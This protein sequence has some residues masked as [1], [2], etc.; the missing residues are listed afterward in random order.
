MAEPRPR[1][2]HVHDGRSSTTHYVVHECPNCFKRRLC[3]FPALSVCTW[4]RRRAY[5]AAFDL[6]IVRR[7]HVPPRSLRV[8]FV[9]ALRCVPIGV[10]QPGATL[11]CSQLQPGHRNYNGSFSQRAF[12]RRSLK[13]L[14]LEATVLQGWVGI[15]LKYRIVQTR[16]FNLFAKQRPATGRTGRWSVAGRCWRRWRGRS[17]CWHDEGDDET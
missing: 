6:K 5:S 9:R 2:G 11:F 13:L 15:L 10:G 16:L 4:R 1:R 3:Y 12:R 17:L 7:V 8:P 14:G